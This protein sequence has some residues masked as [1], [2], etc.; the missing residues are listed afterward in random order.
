MI[1]LAMP[2]GQTWVLILAISLI[3]LLLIIGYKKLIKNFSKDHISL[4]EYCVLYSLETDVASGQV[5][6][7]FT[8]EEPRKV[9]FEIL[10]DNYETLH[11]LYEKECSKGGN[12]ISFDTTILSNGDYFYCLK[13]YNQKTMKKMRVTNS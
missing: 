2:N 6:F 10:N 3:I 8:T 4:E 12:I 7:Y 1:G 13:T 11:I 9:N 5:D